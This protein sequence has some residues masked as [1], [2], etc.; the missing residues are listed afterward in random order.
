[1]QWLSHFKDSVSRERDI[2]WS[3]SLS[4]AGDEKDA[5]VASLRTFQRGLS[6]PGL[7][8]R[9]KVRRNGAEEYA[10]CIDLYV[11]EKGVHADLLA[12][13]LFAS[14]ATPGSR[15]VADFV[16]RHARRRFNWAPELMVL[17]T[18][19]MASVP[20]FRILA[21]Q[22]DDPLL[23]SVLESILYDQSYHLGFHIDHLRQ[24]MNERNNWEVLALQHGW[25]AMF[26]A[27]LGVV[28]TDN[29][30]VF[31]A[32]GYEK[33][34]YWTDAWNLFAQ[35]QTGLNG[36]EYLSALLTRD[37]RLRFVL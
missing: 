6:S 17:L 30:R 12:R 10:E 8:L 26:S 20:F 22:V 16:F 3:Q 25:G 28:M 7:N 23:T 32:L 5:I 29:R 18:A 9:A 15:N 27:T 31:S 19:E 36:S 35:V 2:D 21:N 4:I 13:L 24:E 14:G 1:M 11:Q 34:S 37:P 33:L